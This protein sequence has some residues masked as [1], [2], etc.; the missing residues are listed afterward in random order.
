M[1]VSPAYAEGLAEPILALYS[2]AEQAMLE[3]I[4][5]ALAQ[6]IEAPEWAERKLIELQLIMARI[7]GDL[8]QL[9]GRSAEEIA[10]ALTKAYN[11]GQAGAV[12]DLTE[13][14]NVALTGGPDQLTRFP[15]VEALLG[16]TVDSVQAAHARVLR[17]VPDIY[18]RVV[19]E[20]AGQ[21]LLGTQTRRDVAQS[22]INRLTAR[23]VTGFVDTAGRGWDLTS[24]VE[25]AT[26]TATARAAVDGH[27]DRLQANG[28]D[29]VIVSNAP[30][31]CALCRPFEGKI[32]SLT[33]VPRID[34][35]RFMTTL[36]DARRRGLFHPN[37]R[38]S[39]ALYIPGVTR[40]MHDTADPQGDADRQRLRAL[41]R[42]V[43]AWK[44]RQ[45]VALSDLERARAGA[46]VR[47]Y[48]AKIRQHTATTT[49]KRQPQRE[50][51]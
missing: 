35:V 13:L 31:E 10:L 49:A 19:Q 12:I 5:R 29:L 8:D 2:D 30:Q 24:Y 25:M 38:H 41:E 27:T 6:G 14:V 11:R 18:R 32:L 51:A 34:G 15:A 3:R 47:E 39:T 37:C 20:T 46:K 7:R 45:A 40:P 50:R 1:A 44:R 17:A 16:E 28:H 42:Q 21:V 26:R 48:Q 4:G 9:S 33:G 23:G 22:A 36:D 43:R